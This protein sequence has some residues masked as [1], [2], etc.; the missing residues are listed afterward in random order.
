ML[1]NIPLQK[2]K[3]R[4]ICTWTK[5]CYLL[6]FKGVI[7]TSHAQ[8]SISKANKKNVVVNGQKRKDENLL[9]PFQTSLFSVSE[10]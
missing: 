1:L 10:G 4:Q 5:T 2:V 9:P 7:I 8:T 6:L 3:K